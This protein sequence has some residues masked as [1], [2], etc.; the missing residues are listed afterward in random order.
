[1][2]LDAQTIAWIEA[3]AAEMAHGEIRLIVCDKQVVKII[4]ED[5]RIHVPKSIDNG[6]AHRIVSG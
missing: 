1:M 2:K 6:A 3:V 4:T 5:R